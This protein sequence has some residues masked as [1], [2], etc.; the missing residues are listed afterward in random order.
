MF[1]RKNKRYSTIYHIAWLFIFVIAAG[2]GVF[3]TDVLQAQTPPIAVCD[4]VTEV[5]QQECL[6]LAMLF[7]SAG[8]SGWVNKN[9][10]LQTTALCSWY[11]V[12]CE[13]GH[14]VRLYLFSNNLQGTLP[15]ALANLEQLQILYLYENYL[16]GVIPP[17]LGALTSL[18]RLDLSQNLLSGPLPAALGNLSNVVWLNLSANQLSGS[19]PA[20]LGNLMS[21]QVLRLNHNQLSGLIPPVLG[22]LGNLRWLDLGHNQLIGAIPTA[23]GNLSNITD[24]FLYENQLS[25]S[26]PTD[27]AK[28]TNLVNFSLTYNQLIGALP[29]ELGSLANL[30]KLVL[31]NNQL[32]GTIPP[33]WGNLTKLDKLWLNDNQLTGQVPATLGNLA[34]LQELFLQHNQ[35]SGPLPA[36]LGNL[37]QLR[38]LQLQHNQLS[39]S[40]PAEL[41]SL[42]NLLTLRLNHN[43]LTGPIPATLGNLTTL[44]WLD[45]GHNQLIGAIPP[46]LGNLANLTDLF[47]YENQLSGSLPVE[48]ANLNKLVNLGLGFNQLNGSIPIDYGTLVHLEKM[49]LSHNNL[50]GAI[51]ATLGNLTKLDRL[52]LDDNQLSGELPATFGT[53]TKLKELKVNANKLSGAL[54]ATFPQVAAL[55]QFWFDNTQLCEP[56]VQFFTH[57]LLAIPDLQRTGAPCLTQLTIVKRPTS[58]A[59]SPGMTVTI[60]F[61]I[62]AEANAAIQLTDTIPV[63]LTY[64]NGSA[65]GGISY[66][67]AT[68]RFTAATTIVSTAP[69]I[70]SY[71]ATVD[72]TN[73]P[74]AILDIPTVVSGVGVKS[75]TDST[76]LYIPTAAL[77]KTLVLIYAVG[78][79]DLGEEILKLLNQAEKATGIDPT[80]AVALMVDGPGN[81]DAYLYYLQPDATQLNC[82]NY[83]NVTCNGR[84]QLG[85]NLFAWRENTA[86]VD[87]LQSFLVTTQ[88]AHPAAQ[89]ITLSLVG[90]GSGWSPD[91]LPGQPRGIADQ[92]RG[93]ADQPSAG[94]LWDQSMIGDDALST[95]ELRQALQ[96]AQQATGQAVDLLYLDACSMA[97]AEVA[98]ELSGAAAYL[99]ASQSISWAAFPYDELIM[100]IEDG[101]SALEIGQRWLTIAANRLATHSGI[102]PYTYSLLDLAQ[103]PTVAQ[104]HKTLVAALRSQWQNEALRVATTDRI[105][106]AVQGA[107]C[108]ESNYDGK[109]NNLDTYCDLG[110]FAQQIGN[111]FSDDPLIADAAT[112][113]STMLN[114]AVVTNTQRSGLPWSPAD[115]TWW[116][117]R[118]LHGLSIYLP[119]SPRVDEVRRRYYT[120]SQLGYVAATD[121]DAL[122][123]DVWG[124]VEPPTTTIDCDCP[125]TIKPSPLQMMIRLQPPVAQVQPGTEITTNVEFLNLPSQ[126]ALGGAQIWIS[127]DPSLLEALT[128]SAMTPTG[129]ELAIC[130]THAPGMLRLTLAAPTGLVEDFVAARAR[131]RAIGPA[132]TTSPL[133]LTVDKLY[134]AQ[135]AGLAAHVVDSLVTIGAGTAQ[136][137]GDVNCSAGRDVEDAILVLRYS[138]GAIGSSNQCPPAAGTLY[139]LACDV[140]GNGTCQINDALFLVQCT[141]GIGNVLCPEAMQVTTAGNRATTVGATD[142]TPRLVMA[143]PQVDEE[144]FVTVAV[145]VDSGATRLG[146]ATFT[147]NYDASQLEI[148]RCTTDPDEAFMLAACHPHDTT[149]AARAT[150]NVG[151]LD[152]A[153][154]QGTHQLAEVRFKLRNG[155]SNLSDEAAITLTDPLIVGNQGHH[156]PDN[157]AT[158]FVKIYLPIITR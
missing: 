4:T 46:T 125:A 103:M 61:T 136:L 157:A 94:L 151:L 25:G 79:N 97:M 55:A 51:P 99:L 8:G 39:E 153:G 148:L 131:F 127:Y 147:V 93:I 89:T 138:L 68:R 36:T 44:Q 63:G 19:I 130:H 135:G 108:V 143:A 82:P 119:V 10:W 85:I 15:S 88:R 106:A 100:A 47:L 6:A 102:Y 75:A 69:L 57:W 64:V 141:V 90:H 26:I 27:L 74:G 129:V 123:S 17:E 33:T 155:A 35:L 60:H 113:V 9:G 67:A 38:L 1:S 31:A 107:A 120:G 45:L 21:V 137:P 43:F 149:D 109:I 72:Q 105:L 146:A 24:L 98:Y 30:E 101:M 145:W 91:L 73:P 126:R 133:R 78:D 20:E 142:A 40:I 66:D 139:A 49:V 117:L 118:G 16:T 121:W 140:D 18:T 37:I 70:Y 83:Q 158:D 62:T 2:F 14:V 112:A 65:T 81:S 32:S 95:I 41:G 7:Q 132:G 3:T 59:V 5:P 13:A 128:C 77:I 84:Y 154:V 144:G 54:P 124:G 150:A 80:V 71:Q 122:L 50:T 58:E 110:S 29:A 96:Q 23:F 114:S 87:S 56:N 48:L 53:L 76:A 12:E 104:A 152:A 116:D 42:P 52:W 156:L 115:A 11:G 111:H 92:P 134:D 34:L 22:N 28:L 86:S